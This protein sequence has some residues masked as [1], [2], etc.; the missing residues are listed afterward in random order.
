MHMGFAAGTAAAVAVR[1][2]V[3]LRQVNIQEV[4]RLLAAQGV[5]VGKGVRRVLAT[6]LPRRA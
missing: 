6:P 4:Q 2:D 5:E 1:A 3:T